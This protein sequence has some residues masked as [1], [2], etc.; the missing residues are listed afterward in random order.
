VKIFSPFSGTAD[1][2]ITDEGLLCEF[3]YGW[4]PRSTAIQCLDHLNL[5]RRLNTI[6]R[7]EE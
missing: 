1:R 3:W 6:V 4:H 2:V 7:Q 5:T